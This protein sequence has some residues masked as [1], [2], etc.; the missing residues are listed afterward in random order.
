MTLRERGKG[1]SP[2]FRAG[3]YDRSEH[4]IHPFD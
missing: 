3:A 4:T 2:A 1:I